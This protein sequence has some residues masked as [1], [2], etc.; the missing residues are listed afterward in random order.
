MHTLT[1]S[2]CAL[3]RT[4]RFIGEEL[5]LAIGNFLGNLPIIIN[6][7]V[8]MPITP[9]LKTKKLKKKDVVVGIANIKFTNCF[10]QTNSPNITLAHKSSC[11]VQGIYT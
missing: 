5:I 4:R 8:D 7:Y 2:T 6:N 11:T 1:R 3:Y 10:S 9:L